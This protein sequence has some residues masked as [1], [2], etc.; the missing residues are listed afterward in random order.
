MYK[1]FYFLYTAS[2]KNCLP[3]ILGSKMDYRLYWSQFVM[4]ATFALIMV[5]HLRYIVSRTP[6]HL[7]PFQFCI[8]PRLIQL[9]LHE[10]TRLPGF[11]SNNMLLSPGRENLVEIESVYQTAHRSIMELPPDSRDCIFSDERKLRLYPIYS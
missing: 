8:I 6:C 1:Y 5:I 7:D 11:E 3:I 2:E 10:S 4:K 9:V